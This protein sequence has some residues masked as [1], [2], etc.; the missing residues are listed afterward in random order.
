MH[1]LDDLHL[2]LCSTV[3]NPTGLGYDSWNN[4]T[5]TLP[6]NHAFKACLLS[7]GGAI[8][9]AGDPFDIGNCTKN[10]VLLSATCY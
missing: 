5:S 4:P 7:P 2:V 8:D 10:M 6:R 1:D 3:D 9:V